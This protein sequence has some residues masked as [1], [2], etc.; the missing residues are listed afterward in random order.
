[1][2]TTD[3]IL[4]EMQQQMSVL[5]E[6]LDSQKIVNEKHLRKSMSNTTGRMRMKTRVPIF[7]GL[8]ALWCIPVLYELGLS[9]CFLIFTGVLML[10]CIVA[11]VLIA[12]SIPTLDEDLVTAVGKTSRFRKS[13][14]DWIKF[15]LPAL[16]V[17]LGLLF[18]DLW[19]NTDMLEG[20]VA[21]P[22]VCGILVGILL[23]VLL[24]LKNRRDILNDADDL[25][26]QLNELQ[27][28]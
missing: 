13:E 19:K 26:R 10:V 25:L 15:G 1:M 20:G 14:A 21:V 17:W 4:R 16:A 12:Q 27:Q 9:T 23:G 18:W 5:R 24:G 2:E 6:K 3:N 8:A 22:V 11:T 7:A 28:G